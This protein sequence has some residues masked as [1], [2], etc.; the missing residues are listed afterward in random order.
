MRVVKALP[1]AVALVALAGLAAAPPAYAQQNSFKFFVTYDWISPLGDDHVTV[2]SVSDAVK[3]SDGFGYEAGFEWR[4]HKVVGIEGSYLKGTNDFKFGSTDIGSL[5][6]RAVTAALNFHIIPTKHFD[7]WIGPV[8]SW[9]K[10]D[11]FEV[12]PGN[13]ISRHHR[14]RALHQRLADVVRQ[15]DHFPGRR[16]RPGRRPRR[17][18]V[19]VREALNQGPPGRTGS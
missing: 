16:F 17:G 18:G 5:D 14:W 19:P 7:L 8:F 4:L 2:G 13:S 15:R 6:Q 9:Y 10:F 11:N 3:G 12:S 1:V